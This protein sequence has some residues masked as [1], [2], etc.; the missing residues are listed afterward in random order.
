MAKF[1]KVWISLGCLIVLQVLA[2]INL[3]AF[4]WT[5]QGIGDY[6]FLGYLLWCSSSEWGSAW[7]SQ[8]LNTL[9][10]SPEYSLMW[11]H[12]LSKLYRAGWVY[13]SLELINV[14]MLGLIISIVI[15][16][17]R[18][19]HIKHKRFLLALSTAT[20]ILAIGLWTV[21]SGNSYY[22]D[23]SQFVVISGLIG[24]CFEIGII[25]SCIISLI[26]LPLTYFMFNS[27]NSYL[28]T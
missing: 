14:L 25:I 2:M 17:H 27:N 19:K 26:S 9:S 1:L 4:P 15:Y 5:R 24:S 6:R 13:F 7:Y 16:E 22:S 11:R 8:V 10:G 28:I 18:G 12:K 3:F 23:C 21:L 20:K